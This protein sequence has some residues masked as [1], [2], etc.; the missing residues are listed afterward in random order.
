MRIGPHGP[1]VPFGPPWFAL[2][3]LVRLTLA[4]S[5]SLS[6]EELKTG[7]GVS[8]TGSTGH[9]VTY[10]TRSLAVRLPVVSRRVLQ[11]TW[12][13]TSTETTRLIRDGEKRGGGRES[14]GVGRVG[15]YTYR[16]TCHHQN[17]SC[18]K[19]DSDEMFH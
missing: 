9:Y 11:L 8:A 10:G 5:G 1:A 3:P 14:G 7:D 6:G 16:Y 2:V 18:I 19:V 15:L 17:D 12:C 13:L 4:G